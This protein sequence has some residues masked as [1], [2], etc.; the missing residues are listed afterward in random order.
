MLEHLNPLLV[1]TAVLS[2]L[3]AAVGILGM[4]TRCRRRLNASSETLAQA[5]AEQLATLGPAC[6][7]S[8]PA[9]VLL[10]ALREATGTG[11]LTGDAVRH[12]IRCAANQEREAIRQP[13]LLQVAR[14]LEGLHGAGEYLKAMEA[15]TRRDALLRADALTVLDQAL[16][17]CQALRSESEAA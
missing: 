5:F 16:S 7:D 3:A 11:R 1:A 15:T 17:A 9:A 4:R 13:L 2:V 12:G 8:P 10:Q 14:L 6:A